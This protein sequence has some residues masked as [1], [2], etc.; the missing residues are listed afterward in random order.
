[1]ERRKRAQPV[2]SYAGLWEVLPRFWPWVSRVSLGEI[3]LEHG[4]SSKVPNEISKEEKEKL[5]KSNDLVGS[6]KATEEKETRSRK[7]RG[8]TYPQRAGG[9]LCAVYI[10]VQAVMQR[11]GSLRLLHAHANGRPR[12]AGGDRA[13]SSSAQKQA[14]SCPVL[15]G[16][17]ALPL[18][19]SALCAWTRRRRRRRDPMMLAMGG[20]LKKKRRLGSRR[21]AS[22]LP[23]RDCVHGHARVVG[24]WAAAQF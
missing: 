4:H 1:M 9:H 14:R 6:I 17:A 11:T 5:G 16:L 19:R 10:Q 8:N 24:R 3:D 2:R 7:R 23:E 12:A 18:Y 15:P 21:R 22:C 13:L 20:S